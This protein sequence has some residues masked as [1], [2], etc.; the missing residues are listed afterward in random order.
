M[1]AIFI[2]D[3]TGPGGYHHIGSYHYSDQPSSRESRS[4][5]PGPSTGYEKA[6]VGSS[7]RASE[8]YSVHKHGLRERDDYL[9]DSG[10]YT[11]DSAES[12]YYDREMQVRH[13]KC[14]HTIVL[15]LMVYV[16]VGCVQE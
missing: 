8:P 2:N 1:H 11:M 6:F 9:Q 5:Y 12:D 13:V 15:F 10:G 4:H 7:R 16:G 14:S 3:S